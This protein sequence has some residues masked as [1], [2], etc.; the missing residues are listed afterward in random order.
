MVGAR[1]V[2]KGSR[3]EKNDWNNLRLIIRIGDDY[4]IQLFGMSCSQ[5]VDLDT[6]LFDIL[7]NDENNK[8]REF[9]VGDRKVVWTPETVTAVYQQTSDFVHD[10]ALTAYDNDW[11]E[12]EDL[13]LIT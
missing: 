11:L 13:S 7:L 2:M 4:P 6:E 9:Q 8:D 10:W 5:I 3:N 12:F 1:I